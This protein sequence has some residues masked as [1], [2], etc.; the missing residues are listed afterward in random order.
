MTS[1]LDVI[2]RQFPFFFNFL[3][4]IICNK[5]Q[6]A[7]LFVRFQFVYKRTYVLMYEHRLSTKRK[8]LGGIVDSTN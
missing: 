3:K 8:A 5:R 4:I 7:L 6:S 1:T 2:T